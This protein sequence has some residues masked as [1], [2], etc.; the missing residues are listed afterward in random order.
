MDASGEGFNPSLQL[1]YSNHS[2]ILLS[3]DCPAELVVFMV[4]IN[5]N[6][7]IE[8]YFNILFINVLIALLPDKPGLFTLFS[9]Q[10]HQVSRHES[11]KKDGH[12]TKDYRKIIVERAHVFFILSRL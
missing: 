11:D 8:K 7:Y 3:D 4:Y 12:G 2:L 10:R 5:M 1:P 9:H 6:R